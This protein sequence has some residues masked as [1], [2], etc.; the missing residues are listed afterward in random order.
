MIRTRWL[1]SSIAL[2]IMS[3]SSARRRGVSLPKGK[4]ELGRDPLS[5]I[6]DLNAAA[7]A[8]KKATYLRGKSMLDRDVKRYIEENHAIK[9]IRNSNDDDSDD[10]LNHFPGKGYSGT[11]Y[12][13]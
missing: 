4:V 10:F 5:Y 1:V 3:V 7:T 13:I 9:I 8:E 2:S 6:E 12:L 11:W